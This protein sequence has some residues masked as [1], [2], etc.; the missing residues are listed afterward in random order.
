MARNVQKSLASVPLLAELAPEK[1]CELEEAGHWR[2][3]DAKEQIFDRDSD[4]AE[5]FFVV[6]GKVQILNYSPSGREVSFDEV[7]GGGY[8]G[9]LSALDGGAQPASAVAVEETTVA[10]FSAAAFQKLLLDQPKI[11]FVVLSH[12]VRKVRHADAR[13]MDLSTLSAVDRVYT[14]LLRMAMPRNDGCNAAVINPV[15]THSEIASRAGTTRETVSRVLSN[16]AKATIVRREPDAL[17]VLDLNR[18]AELIHPN[19]V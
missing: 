16:L 1:L 6:D 14:E 2:H 10:S 4:G 12:L 17:R 7:E 11:A 18:L 8:F 9:E 19:D 3:Y 5:I 15:P 13:I